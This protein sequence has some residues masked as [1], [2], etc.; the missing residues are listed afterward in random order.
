DRAERLSRA[1][2]LPRWAAGRRDDLRPVDGQVEHPRAGARYRMARLSGTES[3]GLLRC[4][5]AQFGKPRARDRVADDQE[6]LS[7]DR[8]GDLVRG[9]VPVRRRDNLSGS[10]L[11]PDRDPEEP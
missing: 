6:D 11:R 8:M 2:R 10:G 1:R 4:V 9:W 5:A 3:A 7:A